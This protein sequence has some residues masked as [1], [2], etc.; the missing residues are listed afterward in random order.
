MFQDIEDN[1]KGALTQQLLSH[2]FKVLKIMAVMS[3]TG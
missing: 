3:Y 2:I 1:Q